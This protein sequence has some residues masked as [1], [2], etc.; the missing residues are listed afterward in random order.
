MKE[1]DLGKARAIDD[2]PEAL[3]HKAVKEWFINNGAKGI[4]KSS[5]IA[6]ILGISKRTINNADRGNKLK[7]IGR[8]VYELDDV[9]KWAISNPR[10]LAQDVANWPLTLELFDHVRTTL[11]NNHP[12]FIKVWNNDLEDL[13]SEVCHAMAKKKKIHGVT[14]RTVINSVIMDLWRKTKSR[15]LDSN[16]SLEVLKKEK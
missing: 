6:N 7:A 3:T 9:V 11:Q 8:G 10:V 4:M 14:E 16:V 13:T 2:A 5:V 1:K 12:T 15:H